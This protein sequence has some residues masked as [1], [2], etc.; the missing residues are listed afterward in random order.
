[1]KKIADKVYFEIDALFND[2]RI[3]EQQRVNLY[4]EIWN[5]IQEEDDKR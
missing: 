4:D 2:K 3:T 1:M 5:I